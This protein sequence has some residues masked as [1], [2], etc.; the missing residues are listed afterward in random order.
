[1]NELISEMRAFPSGKHDD[2]VDALSMGLLGL[3]DAGE[4]SIFVPRGTI[5]RGVQSGLAAVGG[6]GGITLPRMRFGL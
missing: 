3:R 6:M 4:A 5:R 1:M 2:M